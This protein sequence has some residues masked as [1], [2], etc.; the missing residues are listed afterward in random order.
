MLLN[1]PQEASANEFWF[2]FIFFNCIVLVAYIIARYMKPKLNPVWG[3]VLI[4]CLYAFW[5]TDYFSF[6]SI[7]YNIDSD[8]RDPL[9]YYLSLISFD[10]YTLYRL[11]IWGVSLLLFRKTCVRLALDLNLSIY[12]FVVFF[13][14]TFSFARASLGM[15]LYFYGL[16]HLLVRGKLGSNLRFDFVKGIMLIVLSYLGHR[17]LLLPI[18]MTPFAYV[19]FSKKTFLI[20]IFAFPVLVIVVRTIMLN[21][22]TG[23]VSI[24]GQLEGFS[25][26]ARSYAS[27]GDFDLNWKFRLIT[28]LRNGSHYV[29]CAYFAYIKL[30]KYNRLAFPAWVNGMVMLSI[31][32]AL[33]SAAMS[34]SGVG[35][36]SVTSKRFLYMTGIP[37]CLILTYLYQHKLCTWRIL[38]YLLLL[39][40][41]WGDGYFVGKIISYY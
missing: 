28:D 23:I 14:L 32:I 10:S 39:A 25:D 29:A 35:V 38:S 17:S 8:F 31:L 15:A 1:L 40:L 41:L 34:L 12:V 22:A 36:A 18:L 19:K 20:M 33:F 9:Y 7:F 2:S 21:F 5:D 3:L 37:I 24:G 6:R 4:F 27:S 26:A 11:M 13:L 30:F 16:S